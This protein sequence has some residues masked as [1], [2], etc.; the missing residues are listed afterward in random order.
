MFVVSHPTGNQNVRAIIN[1]LEHQNRLLKFYTTIARFDNNLTGMFSKLPGLKDL[2][3]RTYSEAVKPYTVQY[4]YYEV[5]RMLYKKFNKTS[6]LPQKYSVDN[7]YHTLDMQVAEYIKNNPKGLEGVYAYEDGAAFQFEE[8]TRLGIKKVY[9]LPIAYWATGRALMM[10]QS[11]I[12]PQWAKTLGGGIKDS[13]EKLDRKVRE[14]ELADVVATPSRFVADSIPAEMNKKV[15]ISPFGSPAPRTDIEQP[16]WEIVK[17]R[18]L[19]ILFAGSMGQRKGLA[20]LFNAVKL[21]SSK[22]IELV[23]VGS[24]QD[25]FQ[26]YKNQMPNFTYLGTMPHKEVLK[27]MASCDV[28]CLPSIVEGRALV[29]QEAMSQGLPIIITPNTGCDDLVTE[30]ET[31]FCVPINNSD[32]IASHIDWFASDRERTFQMKAAARSKALG[33]SWQGYAR[34]VIN[35]L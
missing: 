6:P 27:T 33:Y 18:P 15:I 16:T 32:A 23:V 3:K 25:D 26:F 31:G 34:G 7:I 22:E 20:D 19:K 29:V 24:L 12:Y 13:Q 28:F 8:A 5:G 1:E 9:D 11:E 30:G 4:P 35:N 17:N 10:R 21:L 14:M 2:E